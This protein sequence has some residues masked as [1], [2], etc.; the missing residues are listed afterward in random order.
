MV[1]YKSEQTNASFSS[2]Q[3]NAEVR[4]TVFIFFL[5]RDEN[6]TLQLLISDESNTSQHVHGPRCVKP[7]GN[8][9][10]KQSN[11]S[12]ITYLQPILCTESIQDEQFAL[13]QFC[14]SILFLIEQQL[15]SLVYF[16]IELLAQTF[17]DCTCCISWM[18]PS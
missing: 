7:A 17:A 3:Y 6:L 5:F 9:P 15:T 8:T 10:S 13:G 12:E 2:F 1:G 14:L 16:T 18:F 11:F 4:S